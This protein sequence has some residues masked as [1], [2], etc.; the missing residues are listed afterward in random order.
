MMKMKKM[1]KTSLGHLRPS[2]PVVLIGKG[3]RRESGGI[4]RTL[5]TREVR[6]RLLKRLPDKRLP[7]LPKKGKEKEEG[8][9]SL[10]AEE[11]YWFSRSVS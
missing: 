1:K 2:A 10:F 3:I 5:K 8:G 9:R 6:L 4:G 11:V 7:Q